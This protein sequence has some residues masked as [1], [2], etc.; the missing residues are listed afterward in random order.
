MSA[1]GD[2]RL[3][4]LRM[5][6]AYDS[7]AAHDL[8][9]V[10]P[11]SEVYSTDM[12]A[13][14]GNEGDL[15]TI[16]ND[17]DLFQYMS[18]QVDQ[19]EADSPSLQYANPWQD[20]TP[21]CDWRPS[22]STS[23]QELLHHYSE[24]L[25]H[26]IVL[27]EEPIN[28][29]R[30]CIMPIIYES[31]DSPVLYAVLAFS[32]A[33]LEN[34]GKHLEESSVD[35]YNRSLEGISHSMSN[36]VSPQETLIAIILLVYFE[37]LVRSKSSPNMKAH[38]QDSSRLLRKIE[39][40]KQFE[41]DFLHKA[42]GF[43]DVI[44]SLSTRAKP[45]LTPP[46]DIDNNRGY[47]KG[48]SHSGAID[49][50]LGLSETLWPL[51]YRLGVLLSRLEEWK[52]A[53]EAGDAFDS[54]ILYIAIQ[55]SA[56]TL[57]E[58]LETWVPV[59]PQGYVLSDGNISRQDGQIT[60]DCLTIR[61]MFHNAL[62]YRYAALLQLH[63]AAYGRPRH[64]PCIQEN[65]HLTLSHCMEVTSSNGPVSAL[66]WPLFIAASEAVTKEDRLMA[67]QTFNCLQQRQGMVNIDHASEIIL[68]TWS[69]PFRSWEMV[70]Q[71]MGF[72]IVFG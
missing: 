21:P 10:T 12:W 62:A 38:L 14:F 1:N 49:P 70:E 41:Y 53:V 60:P 63:K 32:A 17:N 61:A 57:K 6:D 26:L 64:H 16:W 28:P 72:T 36:E 65:V 31:Q 13:S 67:T 58:T 54:D 20:L 11:E 42:L 24:V 8:G 43:Y 47:P 27:S 51:L 44:H 69:D 7:P 56:A 48:N 22:W 50:L 37:A 71:E 33:H 40:S 25:S 34:T 15:D 66:L 23:H 29:F 59:I 9:M 35:F 3:N 46:G 68:K 19:L 45:L 39:A 2:S 52:M 4:T 55:T 30:N 5:N 18:G